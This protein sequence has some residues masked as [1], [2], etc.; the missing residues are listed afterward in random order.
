MVRE[1]HAVVV[2]WRRA[3]KK[4]RLPARTLDVYAS[5]FENPLMDEAAKLR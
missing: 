4:L 1:V 2:N 3:A 5:A